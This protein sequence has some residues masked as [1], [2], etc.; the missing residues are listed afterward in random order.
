MTC[1]RCGQRFA[2][3]GAKICGNCADELKDEADYETCLAKM[4]AETLEM[5]QMEDEAKAE[6]NSIPEPEF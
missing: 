3:D 6:S 4:E 1:V 5:M 2:M